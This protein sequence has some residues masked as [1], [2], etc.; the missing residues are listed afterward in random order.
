[1]L[2]RF[3]LTGSLV[4]I[5]LILVFSIFTS[6]LHY[7][8]PVGVFYFSYVY[9][10]F[11]VIIHVFFIKSRMI[12]KWGWFFWLLFFWSFISIIL[13]GALGSGTKIFTALMLVSLIYLAYGILISKFYNRLDELFKVYFYSALITSVFALSQEILLILGASPE[14]VAFNGIVKDMDWWWGVPGFSAEPAELSIVLIPALYYGLVRI[15]EDRVLVLPTF[16][17]MLAILFSSSSLGIIGIL[18]VAMFLSFRFLRGN[19]LVLFFVFPVF[20]IIL[21]QL[22]SQDYFLVRV[23]DSLDLLSIGAY[24][25]P[26]G[27]NLSS[28]SQ[29]VNL[30]MVFR[31][32]RDFNYV[33]VGFSNYSFLYDYYIGDYYIPLHRDDIPGRG[34]ATSLLLRFV[35]EFGL[36]S[37]FVLVL[38]F[39]RFRSFSFN[40]I[41]KVASLIFIIL[42]FIRMGIYFANGTVF[43]LL[44]YACCERGK[45]EISEVK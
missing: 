30:D 40:S 39:Y 23:G 2:N 3:N 44:I 24:V 28:Y 17:I 38:Y 43:F 31:S 9:I 8:S 26:E 12:F 20:S 16:F 10:L 45:N 21:F 15:I 13:N 19:F 18:I 1:M 33:G 5:D 37:V 22:F 25:R 34:S 36:L 11:Y 27:F 41:I 42:A 29:I 32:F 14:Y 4:W 6:G 35:G 7:A